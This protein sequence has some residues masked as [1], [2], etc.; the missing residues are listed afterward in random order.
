MPLTAI[1]SMATK[2]VLN[3]LTQAFEK[4]TG[5]QVHVESV[6]GV[7]ASQRVQ[8]GEV[9]DFVMLGSDAIDKLIAAQALPLNSRLDWVKC[10]IAVAVP[11]GVTH[12][13]IHDAPSVKATI[14]NSATI[15]YSTGPSGV[16]LEKLFKQWGILEQLR[17]RIVVPPP[18]TPV[19]KLIGEQQ[20]VLG[21]QQ[22]S[23]LIDVPGIDIIGTLP[24]EI[25]YITTFSSAITSHTMQNPQRWAQAQKFHEFLCSAGVEEIKRQKGMFWQSSL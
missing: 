11:Q 15:S 16:Y 20:A 9:F 13:D 12:P 21:F 2:T 25:A 4:Q 3:A 6:G 14:L 23:E 8:Q 24:S 1:S 17:P 7:Q 10:H 22:M 5:I 19:G 18:G